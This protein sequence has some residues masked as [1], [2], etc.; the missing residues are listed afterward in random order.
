MITPVVTELKRVSP[1]G[2]HLLSPSVAARVSMAASGRH[3][4]AV[5]G[6][7]AGDRSPATA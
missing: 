6:A 1:H 2:A 7:T 3:A 4:A 5:T